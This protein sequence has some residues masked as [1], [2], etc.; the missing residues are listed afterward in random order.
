MASGPGRRTR[1]SWRPRGDGRRGGERA[2]ARELRE[3]SGPCRAVQAAT[4]APGTFAGW[5]RPRFRDLRGGAGRESGTLRDGIGREPGTLQAVQARNRVPPEWSSLKTWG[6]CRVAQPEDWGTLQ[7]DAGRDQGPC[8]MKQPGTWGLFRV[9]QARTQGPS[10][11]APAK[12]REP[13]REVQ[14]RT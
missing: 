6:P 12:T 4:P 7:G 1:R 13:C 10:E 9:V 8:G 14:A 3:L 5:S 11:M 2:G